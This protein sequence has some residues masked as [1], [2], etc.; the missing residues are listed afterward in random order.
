[1][2]S[3]RHSDGRGTT[4]VTIMRDSTGFILSLLAGKD[5][6][7]DFH[8]ADA[9]AVVEASRLVVE[10][11]AVLSVAVEAVHAC[12]I[13]V[14]YDPLLDL[15]TKAAALTRA[16]FPDDDGGAFRQILSDRGSELVTV[17]WQMSEPG[18]LEIAIPWN[19]LWLPETKEWLGEVAMVRPDRAYRSTGKITRFDDPMLQ[20]GYAESQLS[21]NPRTLGPRVANDR[22]A[23]A[24]L[25][26][27]VGQVDPLAIFSLGPLSPQEAGVFSRWLSLPR[28]L[29]HFSCNAAS[30]GAD[31]AAREIALRSDAIANDDHLAK[32]VAPI[33]SAMLNI[34]NGS[35]APAYRGTSFAQALR[36]RGTPAV[37]S[38]N[39]VVGDHFGSLFARTLYRQLPHRAYNFFAAVRKTQLS[40]T[41][42]FGHPLALFY[43]FEGD[44]DTVIR[45]G[46]TGTP[47]LRLVPSNEPLGA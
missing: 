36:Q 14:I 37:C 33:G 20:V 43:L 21:S 26:G 38:A 39:L 10:A 45:N 34:R 3:N 46:W 28:N 30:I 32:H 25:V 4:A 9:N 31:F 47:R 11:A 1:M 6:Y 5:G 13:D 2:T 19:L 18:Q 16:I 40:L 7:K 42:R 8:A 12:K 15:K 29:F 17:R 27:K 44:I 23:V 35:T 41:R 22:E 24:R